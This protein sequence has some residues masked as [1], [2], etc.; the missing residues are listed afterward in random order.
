MFLQ[1]AAVVYEISGQ[2][3]DSM[4]AIFGKPADIPV[5]KIQTVI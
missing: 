3:V 5:V 1:N 4:S 2:K